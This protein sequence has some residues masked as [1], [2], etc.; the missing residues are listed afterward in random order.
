MTFACS[1]RSFAAVALTAGLVFPVAAS[2]AGSG[3]GGNKGGHHGSSSGGH[4]NS[5]RAHKVDGTF[6]GMSGTTV[7]PTLMVLS[8]KTTINVTVSA[9]TRLTRSHGGRC[10][11]SELTPG[12]HIAADGSFKK[13]SSTAFD[14]RRITDLSIAYTNVAGSVGGVWTGGVTLL[15]AGR[16]SPHSPYWRGEVV[17]VSL[18]PSTKVLS[19]SV[20]L[21]E[22]AVNWTQTPPLHV[23]VSGLYD[24]ANHDSANHVLPT[25]RADAVRIL[26][27]PGQ[28][29]AGATG[30]AE[31]G[32]RH[33]GATGTAEPGET[34]ASATG[35][36]ESG[37]TQA[38]ATG[39]AE[40][41]RRHPSATPTP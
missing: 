20:T 16:G 22:S 3:P 21:T 26:G 29:H 35:T 2:A 41:G 31:P 40:P 36:A 8:G 28:R 23:R 30:T 5:S 25:L 9:R 4:G 18:S 14:A 15:P 24:T 1:R 39:T 27:T 34:H 37:E 12:D 17:N 10:S 13:G 32:Q 6:Q 33:A 7:P 11:L 19:G 38:S